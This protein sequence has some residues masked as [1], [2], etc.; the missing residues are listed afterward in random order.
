MQQPLLTTVV[1]QQKQ[2]GNVSIKSQSFTGYLLAH[3]AF[4]ATA[5]SSML[6]SL[7]SHEVVAFKALWANAQLVEDWLFPNLNF[8]IVMKIRPPTT[9]TRK[10]FFEQFGERE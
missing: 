3:S 10:I 4:K 8:L 1:I 6:T 9:T 7:L 5:S 2:A